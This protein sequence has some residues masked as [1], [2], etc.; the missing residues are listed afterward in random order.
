[1][2]KDVWDAT[3]DTLALLT[4]AGE[5]KMSPRKF[6]LLMAALVRDAR[7]PRLA[8][9]VE[10]TVSLAERFADGLVE[11]RQVVNAY[12]DLDARWA[13]SELPLV[14][15]PDPGYLTDRALA[16]ARRLGGWDASDRTGDALDEFV[17]G[18]DRRNR[19]VREVF[20]NPFRKVAVEPKWLTATVHGLARAAYQTGRFDA[21][22]LLADALEEVGC[23][24]QPLL[25][26]LRDSAATHIRGCWAVDAILGKG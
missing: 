7:G 8:P 14:L 26:H 23:D 5:Q 21:L 11:L 12:V 1:M 10:Q 4:A 9:V 17:R 2:D 24:S 15:D 25:D 13:G 18:R 3:A 16:V 19:F 6:R 20:G 22:P